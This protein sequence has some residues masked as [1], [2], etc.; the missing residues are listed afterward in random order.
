LSLRILSLAT[1]ALGHLLALGCAETAPLGS[2][3]AADVAQ[4]DA[5][6]PE[7][8][9]ESF[10]VGTY[11]QPPAHECHVLLQACTV[12]GES[13]YFTEAGAECLATGTSGCGQRC[14]YAN[15]CPV[16]TACAGDPGYCFG[17]CNAG[18]PCANGA[19]CREFGEVEAVGYCPMACSVLA[20]D[21]P[22]GLGCF[23]VNGGEECAPL[24]SPSFKENQVCKSANRCQ[25]GLVCHKL[26]AKRCLKAC[27]IT[28]RA[29]P[30]A[31]GTCTPLE[32][33]EPLGV[34]V[35]EDGS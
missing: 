32:G 10:V 4:N 28:D 7:Y 30:C 16:G 20:Q 19:T 14:E 33:L 8:S 23:L 9:C 12:P 15:D 35:P 27:H 18:Q 21:C 26:D 13:C 6:G 1:L 31:T 5:S 24:L 11:S 25:V 29:Y 34:C 2:D 17:L 22:D 3:V